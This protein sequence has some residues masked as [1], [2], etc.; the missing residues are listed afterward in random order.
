MHLVRL[1]E[2]K[3]IKGC[4]CDTF[5]ILLDIIVHATFTQMYNTLAYYDIQIST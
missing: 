2:C 3:R 1:R 4:D 5:C